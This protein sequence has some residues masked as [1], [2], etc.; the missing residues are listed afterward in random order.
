MDKQLIRKIKKLAREECCNYFDGQCVYGHN[1]AAIHPKYAAIRDGAIGCDYFLECVLPLDP[2][3]NKA[4]WAELL[5]YEEVETPAW[6]NCERCGQPYL[7]NS[8]RQK[9]CPE[10]RPIQEKKRGRD[11]QRRYY[12][13][14]QKKRP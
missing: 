10:C 1:R 6:K 2:E 14:K 13:R 7:P 3:L 4:V 8:N 12:Q 9:Y 11:K 5:R